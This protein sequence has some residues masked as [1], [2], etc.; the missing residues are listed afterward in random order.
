MDLNLTA[1]ELKFRDE[2][3]A[4]LKANV[5]KDWDNWREESL[6]ARFGYLKR[7]QRKLYEGG[8][9]GISWP[10]EYGGRGASLMQQ[11]IF[12]QEMALANIDFLLQHIARQVDDIH[13]V[14]QRT[15]NLVFH[16]TCTD[17]EHL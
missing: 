15:R 4:W 17:K 6:E 9:A 1:E 5:P 10:K 7:W 16:I 12:W 8:W 2:L 14:G 13:A 11:V 3:R